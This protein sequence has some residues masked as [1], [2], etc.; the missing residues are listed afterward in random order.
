MAKNSKARPMEVLLVEDSP[1]EVLIVRN[2]IDRLPSLHLMHVAGDGIDAMEFLQRRG[3][4][5]NMKLPD[6][7]LLDL[8]MPQKGGFEV[9]SEIK[10]DAS[11]RRLPVIIFTTSND[12]A[13]IERAYANGANTFIPKPVT[14]DEMAQVLSH[15]ANYWTR[16]AR[17]TGC[18]P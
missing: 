14:G 18:R 4:Y 6:L 15:F 7:V 8:N 12:E 11:L 3:R 2:A 17:L 9:L 5:E 16:A 1:M 13:D 10:Q